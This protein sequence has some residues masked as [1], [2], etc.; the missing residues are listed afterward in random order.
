MASF[1]SICLGFG[2]FAA[3]EGAAGAQRRPNAQAALAAGAARP[4]GLR[5]L[6]PRQR[7]G[8]LLRETLRY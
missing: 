6:R 4:R 2:R 5:A 7:R 8:G 3:E 1:V